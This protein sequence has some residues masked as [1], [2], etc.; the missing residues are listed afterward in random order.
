MGA[1]SCAAGCCVA[2]EKEIVGDA[3]VPKPVSAVLGGSPLEPI[4]Q[5]GVVKEAISVK[6]QETGSE[7]KD[8]G[9]AED[10]DKEVKKATP[11]QEEVEKT[12][13]PDNWNT[14]EPAVP[15]SYRVRLRREPSGG[16]GLGLAYSVRRNV[17]LVKYVD[18]ASPA[19]Q[20]NKEYA[21][22]KLE[23][24]CTIAKVNGIVEATAIVETVRAALEIDL[25]VYHPQVT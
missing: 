1:V 17:V 23:E 10:K 11:E 14:S 21:D 7:L 5:N 22:R 3:D 6:A 4:D 8:R 12:G 2:S 13:L 15:K 24:G 16:Y 20:W 25:T 18:A 9:G 19:D